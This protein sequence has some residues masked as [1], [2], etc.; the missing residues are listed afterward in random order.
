[1]KGAVYADV[2]SLWDYKGPT[3]FPATNESIA[4]TQNN[5]IVRAS[6]GAGI[7]WSS[8]FGPLRFDYAVPIAKGPNDRTQVFRFGGTSAF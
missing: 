2:G 1:L 4:V 7:I 3:E 6:V 5:M 8:P